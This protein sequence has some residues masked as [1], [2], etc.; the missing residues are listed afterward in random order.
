MHRV[1]FQNFTEFELQNKKTVVNMCRRNVLLKSVNY[2]FFFIVA[3]SVTIKLD[4]YNIQ[5]MR[6]TNYRLI[7]I[8]TK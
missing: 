3:F 7:Q 6:K 2:V 4:N 5:Y 8:I 1:V